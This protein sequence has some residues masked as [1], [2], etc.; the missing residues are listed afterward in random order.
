MAAAAIIG[1]WDE[2]LAAIR[3]QFEDVL[4]T[5]WHDSMK[6][7]AVTT[8][9]LG[10]ILRLWGRIEHECRRHVE[11]IAAGWDAVGDALS[12]C[13]DGSRTVMLEQGAKRDAATRLLGLRLAQ[14]QR[15]AVGHGAAAMHE[16]A[17]RSGGDALRVFAA[18]GARALAE[19]AS[20]PLYEAMVMA[21][22]RVD[23]FDDRAAVPVS[24]LAD[25]EAAA[26][27]YWQ[28]LFD[29]EAQWAPLQQPYV[30]AH[31]QRHMHDVERKL[32][33]YWQ[34]RTRERAASP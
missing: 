6:L 5:A 29:A 21:E 19:A 11:R 20:L 23:A 18:C 24:T 33:A 13:P 1:R 30:H 27:R 10:P 16:H 3:Q 28:A 25:Y 12:A 26:R 34:W 31:V 7:V 8:L 22:L 14:V 2:T 4:A 17:Q 32:S 15:T 9:D